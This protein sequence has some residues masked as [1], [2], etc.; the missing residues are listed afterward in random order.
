M[1]EVVTITGLGAEGDGAATYSGRR[2]DLHSAGAAGRDVARMKRAMR[3]SPWNCC[4]I[5]A[6]RQIRIDEPCGGCVAR[7][8]PPAM[9]QEWKRELLVRA[10]RQQGITA[11]V[12][13]LVT[14]PEHSRRRATFNARREGGAMRIGYH[15]RRSHD[16]V[17]ADDCPVL[18][19]RIVA[20]LPSLADLAATVTAGADTVRVVV[21]MTDTG[22]DVDVEG[23]EPG[24]DG[25]AAQSDQ[26]DRGG[27]ADGA[28]FGWRRT[29]D[30]AAGAGAALC[31][32]SRDAAARR[33]P[34]GGTRRPSRR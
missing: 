22:A 32:E 16:L 9:Y 19:M 18:D 6:G 27:G 31:R 8:M 14:V 3:R 26:R 12:Q 4:R 13:P 34:S 10:L 7:H 29:G 11:D 2:A 21:T 15:G 30:R 24:S 1:S 17:A 5:G 25:A 20:L 33:L 28:Y 23:N